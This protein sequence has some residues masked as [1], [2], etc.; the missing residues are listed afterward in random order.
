VRKGQRA[1]KRL[2]CSWLG[3]N[4]VGVRVLVMRLISWNVRGLGG[5]EKRKEVR[6]LVKDK[7]PLILCLQE[8]KLQICDDRVC[9]SVWD[10]LSGAFSFRPFVGASGGLLTVWDS[11]EVE[12]WS[13]GSF[14]HVLSIHGRF[15]VS[16]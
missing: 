12:V 5:P 10:N 4:G 3:V 11:S 14:D 15:I 8:T 1:W 13:T 9:S 2:R 16:N 7:R 6:S